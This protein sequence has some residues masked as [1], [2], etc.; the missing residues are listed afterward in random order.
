MPKNQV[1]ETEN[2]QAIL[3]AALALF[4][5][6]G[7]DATPVPEIAKRAGLSPGTI[8]R[9]FESKEDLVNALYRHWKGTFFE[10]MT[11]GYPSG[12]P[13]RTRFSYFFQALVQFWRRNPLAFEFLEFHHHVHY[14]DAESRAVYREVMGF[15]HEFLEDTAREEITKPLP[16]EAVVAFVLG[17]F[18]GL[19]KAEKADELP[20]DDALLQ[21]IEEC[22]WE[23]IRR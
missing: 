5:A 13:A 20:L 9:Y 7:F 8:Y 22:C 18:T 16:P 6:R 1:L 19:V 3:D 4:A 15:I 21:S 14:L 17:A 10:M 2:R 12:A 11:A 23:A